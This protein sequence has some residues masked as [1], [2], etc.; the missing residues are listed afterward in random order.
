M[1]EGMKSASGAPLFKVFQR[2][3]A[4]VGLV[5]HLYL[6]QRLH[7]RRIASPLGMYVADGQVQAD[8]LVDVM[9]QIDLRGVGVQVHQLHIVAFLLARQFE[10]L[11]LVARYRLL[12]RGVAPV[13]Q[14][15]HVAVHVDAGHQQVVR[16]LQVHLHLRPAAQE[17]LP[18]ASLEKVRP[19]AIGETV[20]TVLQAADGDGMFG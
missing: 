4:W 3:P 11:P 16:L 7:H 2:R 13:A 6:L 8:A 12:H 20:R 1:I 5:V 9:R 14:H 18:A 10:D 15:V 17:I 19:Q